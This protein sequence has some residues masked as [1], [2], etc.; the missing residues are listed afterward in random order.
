VQRAIPAAKRAT[1]PYRG[2]I[3]TVPDGEVLPGISAVRQPGHTPGHTCYLVHSR[4]ETMIIWG[5]TVHVPEVQ[6]GDP[7]IGMIFDT[8]SPAAAKSR[9]R[10]LQRCV[11]E[12]LLVAGMHI[13]FPGFARIRPGYRGAYRFIQEQ[14]FHA[15]NH[16]QPRD[17]TAA[18]RS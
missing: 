3:R 1:A 5:D 17:A 4:G 6:L 14:W 12:D 8:D 16:G 9:R 10:I 13:H 15:E 2:R 7:D 18:R 11:D